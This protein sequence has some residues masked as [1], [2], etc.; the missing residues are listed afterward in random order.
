M[1][2]KS[3]VSL[4]LLGAAFAAP[5]EKRQVATIQTAVTNVGTSLTALDTAI[6][7]VNGPAD[8]AKVLAASQGVQNALMTGATMVNAG[9]PISLQDALGLQQTTSGLTTQVTTTITDLMGKKAI[10]QQAGQTQTTLQSLQAQKTAA[11]AFAK[12]VTSKVPAGVQNIAAN[13]SGMV[14]AALD[15]GIAAF[16]GPAAPAA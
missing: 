3:I 4:A 10:I 7:A 5:V 2:F 16:G 1:L 14:S 15:K 11:D 9:Q 13:Q 6:K 8:T 12:A